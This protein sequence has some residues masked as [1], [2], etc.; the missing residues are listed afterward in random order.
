MP[1]AADPGAPVHLPNAKPRDAIRH[2]AD[3]LDLLDLLDLLDPL[4][5]FD[6]LDPLSVSP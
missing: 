5:L 3:P 1:R 2:D 6:L 4:D